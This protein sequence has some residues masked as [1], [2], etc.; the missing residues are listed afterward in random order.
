MKSSASAPGRLL[1]VTDDGRSAA[2]VEKLLRASFF[3]SAPAARE[4]PPPATAPG[5]GGAG[6]EGDGLRIAW[7]YRH[8]LPAASDEDGEQPAASPSSAL[9]AAS[10]DGRLTFERLVGRPPGGLLEADL[11]GDAPRDG[12]ADEGGGWGRGRPYDADQSCGRRAAELA[13]LQAVHALRGRLAAAGAGAVF[14][15]PQGTL[16]ASAE[17]RLAHL[18]HTALAVRAQLRR[19]LPVPIALRFS[20]PHPPAPC[21]TQVGALS[22]HEPPPAARCVGLVRV[23]KAG[24]PFPGLFATTLKFPPLPPALETPL[25]MGPRDAPQWNGPPHCF[26]S[27]GPKKTCAGA[28]CGPVRA[29]WV[30]GCRK[31]ACADSPSPGK[32]GAGGSFLFCRRVIKL[33]QSGLPLPC[34]RGWRWPRWT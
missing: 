1:L 25:V 13:V 23:N 15:A 24:W 17:H 9:A 6:E 34:R 32:G 29:A 18:A 12:E 3:S 30:G 5:A 4:A 19:A 27:H 10:P 16:G 20:L 2:Y 26:P 7:Q 14:S 21:Y 22:E 28:A 11:L 33:T 31:H 8:R